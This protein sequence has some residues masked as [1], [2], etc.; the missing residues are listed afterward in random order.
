MRSAAKRVILSLLGCFDA[1]RDRILSAHSTD[2]LIWEKEN[3]LRID[4]GGSHGCEMVYYPYAVAAPEGGYRL[5]YYGSFFKEGRW[6][7]G[8]LSALSSDGLN[9]HE[10]RGMRL[11]PGNTYDL[12]H[13]QS[14]CVIAHREREY[15]LYYTGIAEEG[16]GKILSAHSEDQYHW[17][18]EERVLISPEHIDSCSSVSDPAVMMLKEGGMR[19]YFTGTFGIRQRILSAISFDGSTWQVEKGV[20]VDSESPG[21][22]I[23]ANNPSVVQ[24][25]NIFT[26]YFRGGDMITLY[27]NIYSARSED[28]IHWKVS[29][30]AL[31][32]D[33]K[34]RYE[35]HSVGF[36][37]VMRI[38][39]GLWR[40]YYT[41]YW[42][43]FL[44]EKK[45]LERWREVNR[46][47]GISG[48]EG[49]S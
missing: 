8:I 32:F 36:P 44:G 26:M 10:E 5:F 19:M 31:P 2:G 14:P 46:A 3:G 35:R 27:N 21:Y 9:W 22:S 23:I 13:C 47:A 18:K 29:G 1:P 4:T 16:V 6:S 37:M 28:G 40:M 45:L 25:D 17:M 7:G 43:R 11:S 15:I 48:R 12:L 20:R 30:M 33:Q 49:L 39:A 24:E 42:G 38:S 34:H 41:G